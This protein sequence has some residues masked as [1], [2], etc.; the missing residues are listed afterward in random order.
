MGK[1][2]KRDQN[3]LRSLDGCLST[4]IQTAVTIQVDQEDRAGLAA[5][6][7]LP[8]GGE[9]AGLPPLCPALAFFSRFTIPGRDAVPNLPG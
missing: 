3:R 7:L 4:G 8:G 2:P 9:Y 5:G 1:I 6:D